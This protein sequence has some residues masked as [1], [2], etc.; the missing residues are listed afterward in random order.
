RKIGPFRIRYS[1]EILSFL[2]LAWPPAA[3]ATASAAPKITTRSRN[4]SVRIKNSVEEKNSL[5]RF[6]LTPRRATGRS[7]SKP[8][9]ASDMPTAETARVPPNWLLPLHS[10]TRPPPRGELDGKGSAQSG[11]AASVNG[12]LLSGRRPSLDSAAGNVRSAQ[13]SAVPREPP[14][15]RARLRGGEGPR[16]AGS[17]RSPPGV[18]S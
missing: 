1:P 12:S 5:R 13:G 17:D 15:L 2:A 18:R 3:S 4:R 9:C 14:G 16:A 7:A 6:P 8:N 11:Q 10:S